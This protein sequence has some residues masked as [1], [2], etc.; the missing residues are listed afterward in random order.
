[1]QTDTPT[2]P[3]DM[4]HDVAEV[5]CRTQKNAA[6]AADNADVSKPKRKRTVDEAPPTSVDISA[7]Y[8][9]NYFG[10][11]GDL[12]IETTPIT[13]TQKTEKTTPN[14]NTNN[15][16]SNK[17]P[18]RKSFCPP[19]FL[20]NVNVKT[21]VDQLVSKTPPIT[22]KIKNVSKNKSKLYLADPLVHTNMMRLLRDKKVEAYSFTPKELKQLSLIMRG[23][24]HGCEVSQ[25]TE[26]FEKIAPG[27]VSK[28]TKYTT[29][30][31]I[32][33]SLDTGLFLVTLCPGK[34]LSD[35]AHIKYLLSQVVS[36]ERP[37]KKEQELQCHRCQKWGHAAK[38]CS[39]E[40]KC[41]KCDKKHLPGECQRAK[42]ESSDPH[43]VN[44]GEAGHP[45][46][47][48]GCPSYKGFVK[49]KKEKIAKARMEQITAANNLKR[50]TSSGLRSPGTTFAQLFHPQH[51]LPLQ[52]K[53]P[54]IIDE[55]LK[56]SSYFL[57]PEE[58]SLEEE[59]SIFMSEFRT[60][61]EKD[62]K[63]EFLRLL[64]K[65]KKRRP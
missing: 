56:L 47:F 15:K 13:L 31:S 23:L 53:T 9:Q 36:W 58:L 57:E 52:E 55:F 44:C 62:A 19:I 65:V 5:V 64:H 48:R 12:E 38:N 3:P 43:C 30:Y 32:K 63:K 2:V 1:M 34:K 25:V 7:I 61:S 27:V 49:A 37:K 6:V 26:E 41:V 10:I 24:Y 50:A 33:N 51:N 28:V 8:G 29:K 16:S 20:Y 39:A 60:L 14:N 35:V 4:D 46:N 45:A 42:T 59:I 21:F 18:S 11:L 54:S 40:F 22:F 17:P